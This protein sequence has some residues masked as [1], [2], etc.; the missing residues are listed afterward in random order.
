ML[1]A[2]SGLPHIPEM[3][4]TVEAEKPALEFFVTHH[5]NDFSEYNPERLKEV[6]HNLSGMGVNSQRFDIR[7]SKSRPNRGE[8]DHGYLAKSGEVAKTAQEAGLSSIVVLSSPPKWAMELY[9][10][11]KEAFFKEYR[12]YVSGVRE[13][14]GA[15]GVEPLNVQ[16]FNELNNTVYTPKEIVGD[17]PQFCAIAR[18]VFGDEV[19]LTETVLAGNLTDKLTATGLQTGVMKFLSDY[20]EILK[21]SFDVISV[22]YYPG[23]YHLPIKEARGIGK[24][25]FKQTGYLE[26]V[27]ETISTWGKEIEVGEVGFPTLKGIDRVRS[28]GNDRRQRY[29]FDVFAMSIKPLVEKF[30]IKRIGFYQ[31]FDETPTELGVLNFG[32]WDKDGN[33]KSVVQDSRVGK[34]KIERNV[35]PQLGNIIR[36]LKGERDIPKSA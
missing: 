34:D 18:E 9:K 29:A 27:L 28:I 32:L 5:A 33:P 7:W 31:V 21:S 36:Y 6:L 1:E 30:G 11:D 20:G 24:K 19:R 22:D 13:A 14:L 16:I 35:I 25:L 17:L 8:V 10:T 12:S 4:P 23:L 3:A 26:K 2:Q 15:V